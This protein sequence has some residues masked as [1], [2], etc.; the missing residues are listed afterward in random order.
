MKYLPTI[1]AHT[2]D[3]Y[4]PRCEG[5]NS[6]PFYRKFHM[7]DFLYFCEIFFKITQ[8]AFRKMLLLFID[9]LARSRYRIC[10]K[11]Q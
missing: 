8:N 1:F 5:V 11:R 3:P 2:S 9:C 7:V 10:A 4:F 6:F